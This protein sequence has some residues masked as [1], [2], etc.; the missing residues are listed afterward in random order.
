MRIVCEIPSLIDDA[1]VYAASAW[2]I[3]NVVFRQRFRMVPLAPHA[4]KPKHPFQPIIDPLSPIVSP[5]HL[6]EW[7]DHPQ[8]D[9][10]Q[11]RKAGREAVTVVDSV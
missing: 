5:E 3:C 4:P 7:R 6:I 1:V 11:R 2:A 10:E 9:I 8:R